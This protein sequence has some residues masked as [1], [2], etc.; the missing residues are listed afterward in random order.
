MVNVCEFTM[1]F[2]GGNENSQPYSLLISIWQ[3]Y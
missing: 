3:E 2:K 1:N